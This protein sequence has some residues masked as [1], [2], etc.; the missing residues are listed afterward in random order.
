MC[1]TPGPLHLLFLAN[2]LLTTQLSAKCPTLPHGLQIVNR[3]VLCSTRAADQVDGSLVRRQK[4]FRVAEPICAPCTSSSIS[5]FTPSGLPPRY[6]GSPPK[7]PRPSSGARFTRAGSDPHHSAFA[8]RVV[9]VFL[10]GELAPVPA[11]RAR[12]G[13]CFLE[14]RC[15]RLRDRWDRGAA[16]T[17][18]HFPPSLYRFYNK[19]ILCSVLKPDIRVRPGGHFCLFRAWT[20]TAFLF[21]RIAG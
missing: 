7:G 18:Y 9:P 21:R 6:P 10:A 15:R 1:A 2:R 5:N 19:G 12:P 11:D 16:V 17:R 14:I 8:D 3:A 4:K 13:I 20:S